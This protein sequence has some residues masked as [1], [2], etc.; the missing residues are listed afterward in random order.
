[1]KEG[2]SFLIDFVLLVDAPHRSINQ[3]KFINFEVHEFQ[4]K[5]F[6]VEL[7]C[8]DSF[9]CFQLFFLHLCCA[10]CTLSFPTYLV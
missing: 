5:S 7:N 8:L 9:A 3:Y 10:L 6:G 2:I 4:Y 1:M